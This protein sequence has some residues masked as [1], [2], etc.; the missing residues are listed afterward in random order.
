LF[1]EGK[2]F[3]RKRS[4]VPAITDFYPVTGRSVMAAS[5]VGASRRVPG[6]RQHKASGQWIVEI[7]GKTN[8]LGHDRGKAQ[9]QYDALIED[10]LKARTT[11]PAD[12][13]AHSGRMTVSDAAAALVEFMVADKGD[14][15]AP[16]LRKWTLGCLKPFT[17]KHGPR[18]VRAVSIDDIEAYRADLVR[19]LS[20]KTA[21]DYLYLA[22][23]VMKYAAFKGWRD[24]MEMSF[25]KPPA[26]L[27]PK[28]KH[29][30]VEQIKKMLDD[31]K[32]KTSYAGH[33]DANL[34]NA[35]RIQL[36]TAARPSEIVRLLRR[37]FDEVEP[38]VF[39]LN[40]GKTNRASSQLRCLLLSKAARALLDQTIV[41]WESPTAYLFACRR[42]CARPPHRLRHSGAFLIHRCGFSRETTDLLL[43]HMEIFANRISL[44]YNPIHWEPLLEA[45]E[46]YNRRLG[47]LMP[48]HCFF[49]TTQK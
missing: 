38:G 18:D 12:N 20:P 42:A 27:A 1:H 46:K 7:S 24:P 43:G 22:K 8:Y 39:Q 41:K 49:A 44:V 26:L 32:A 29:L 3:Y 2:R 5:F 6:L 33:P 47:E 28:P 36:M 19:R 16:I 21:S 45:I 37:R 48:E 31:A 40:E 14:E 10:L 11:A 35:I 30:T 13:P 34:Y 15:R 9:V 25:I 17:D 23:R 4:D